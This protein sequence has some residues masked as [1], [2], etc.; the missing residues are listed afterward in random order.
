MQ[1]G[2]AFR[3]SRS[4]LSLAC[5]AAAFASSAAVAQQAAGGT[6]LTAD[7][8][9]WHR[10]LALGEAQA[11]F[12]DYG[13]Q[14]PNAMPSILRDSE[15]KAGFKFFGGY[16][17]GSIFA[18]AGGF[19]DPRKF[20]GVQDAAT[21]PFGATSGRTS[22]FR[23]DAVGIVPIRRGLSLFGKI[24]TR[25]SP[26]RNS[27]FAGAGMLAPAF[28]DPG[29]K[30][31]EWNANYGLGASYDVSNSIGL[32]FKYERANSYFGDTRTS[33]GNVGIWSLGLIRRY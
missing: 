8:A 31:Y 21:A 5:F 2:S 26:T 22:G 27:G 19:A 15:A 12:G 28:A 7:S 6:G 14:L 24:G 16:R 23:L 25:Y 18:L 11:N 20:D 1:A 4:S 13:L 29:Q 9:R 30:R 10:G 17:F 3:F 33:E 32:H